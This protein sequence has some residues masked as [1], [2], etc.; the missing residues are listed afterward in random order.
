MKVP[1]EVIVRDAER[2]IS[3]LIDDV[4]AAADQSLTFLYVTPGQP[5]ENGVYVLRR[6]G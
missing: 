5:R 2:P 3:T 1:I 4:V 6:A